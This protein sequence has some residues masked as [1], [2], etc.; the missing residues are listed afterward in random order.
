MNAEDIP[1]WDR[2]LIADV[3]TE[4]GHWHAEFGPGDREYD[5]YIVLAMERGHSRDDFLS[6]MAAHKRHVALEDEE[7]SILCA[8]HILGLSAIDGYER[9]LQMLEEDL[10]RGAYSP[11]DRGIFFT[12]CEEYRAAQDKINRGDEQQ[13]RE[14]SH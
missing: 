10:R 14:E 1:I 4:D 13:M 3:A 2:P 9:A 8:V 5:E 11:D 12:E 6:T 7:R